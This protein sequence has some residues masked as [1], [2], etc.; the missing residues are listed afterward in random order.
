MPLRESTGST[1]G[2][3]NVMVND[4]RPEQGPEIAQL[5]VRLVSMLTAGVAEV[6]AGFV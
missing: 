1:T 6:S 3:L 5:F 2:A 4:P